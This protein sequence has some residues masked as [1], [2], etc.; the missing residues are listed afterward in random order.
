M[1]ARLVSATV[2]TDPSLGFTSGVNFSAATATAPAAGA[3]RLNAA[4]RGIAVLAGGRAGRGR[5]S[6][7]ASL[8]LAP[9]R[10][11]TRRRAEAGRDV[12]RGEE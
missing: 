1:K 8:L 10:G 3:R 7:V 5:V 6:C 9:E 4:A 12:T 11:A 2:G